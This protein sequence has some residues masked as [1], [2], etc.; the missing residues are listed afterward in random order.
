MRATRVLCILLACCAH[1]A[2]PEPEHCSCTL[3]TPPE[4][5]PSAREEEPPPIVAEHEID[6]PPSFDEM[7]PATKAM[8]PLEHVFACVPHDGSSTTVMRV[9]F[10]IDATGRAH[11]IGTNV[12]PAV[13]P[14]VRACMM[15][16]FE[17]VKFPRPNGG[18][19]TVTYPILFSP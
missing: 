11:F 7:A 10:E 18:K 13:S 1:R 5:L 15:H 3:A 2:P 9:V 4:P 8:P 12:D 19:V 17:S 6:G 16:A 14:S